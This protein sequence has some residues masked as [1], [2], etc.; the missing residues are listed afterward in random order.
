MSSP[1]AQENA[2][3]FRRGA[4]VVIKETPGIWHFSH[5]SWSE[6]IIQRRRYTAWLDPADG[7]AKDYAKRLPYGMLEALRENI[8]RYTPKG[9]P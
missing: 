7:V 9:T 4:L 5:Y 3:E 8:S 6:H 2:S 1:K